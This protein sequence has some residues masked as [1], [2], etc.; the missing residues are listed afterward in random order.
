MLP[1]ETEKQYRK[2]GI[3]PTVEE[4]HAQLLKLLKV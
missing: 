1:M 3:A 2:N 4:Y